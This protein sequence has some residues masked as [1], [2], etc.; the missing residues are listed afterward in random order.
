MNSTDIEQT[1]HEYEQI[2]AGN[3]SPEERKAFLVDALQRFGSTASN[4]IDHEMSLLVHLQ[5]Q[6]CYMLSKEGKYEQALPIAKTIAGREDIERKTRIYCRNLLGF[7]FEISGDI[8]QALEQYLRGME[9]AVSDGLKN[10]QALCAGNIGKIYGRLS[11]YSQALFYFNQAYDLHLQNGNTVA[12][13]NVTTNIGIVYYYVG[14]FDNALEWWN[15]SLVIYEEA[16]DSRGVMSAGMHLGNLYGEIGDFENAI[17]WYNKAEDIARN[18]E[19]PVYLVEIIGNLSATY[20]QFGH[21]DKALHYALESIALNDSAAEVNKAFHLYTA[22][23]ILL[24]L[25]RYEEA[26]QYLFDAITIY[27]IHP[28]KQHEAVLL[29]HLGALFSTKEF[30][31]CDVAKA[32]EYYMQAIQLNE[33]TGAHHQSIKLYSQLTDLYAEQRQWEQAY[34]A[35]EKHQELEKANASE[36]AKLS[37]ERIKFERRTAEL[38]KQFVAEKARHSATQQILHNILP[39]SIADRIIGGEKTIAESF[40]MVSIFFLDIVGFTKLSSRISPEELVAGL[41]S[42]F[43]ELDRLAE[44]HGI[45]KIKTIGDSYMAVCGVPEVR[46]DHAER[47]ALFA[48]DVCDAIGQFR[49]TPDRIGVTI[50]IGL[51]CGSVV[52]GVI[53]ERKF[54]YDLWGDAVNTA[55]RMESHCTAGNIHV[56]EEFMQAIVGTQGVSLHFTPRGEIDIK[57][58]GKMSTY[59]ME[60]N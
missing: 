42:I 41:N 8:D 32:E 4:G 39:V 30:T 55:S 3:S 40:P 20:A 56:S 53:G 12:S 54:A 10:E 43:T 26:K 15:K 18:E 22:G 9:I 36:N 25:S 29:G 37:A 44:R 17:Y 45:E 34:R 52:A 33:E 28:S 35:M 11:D 7:L 24:E 50:R 5:I 19:Y 48:L 60:R 51:H 31:G 46:A 23:A 58:I 49:F 14:D 27:S 57:G 6:L 1:L 47:M 2:S 38:D 59:F 21:F 16:E 13:A